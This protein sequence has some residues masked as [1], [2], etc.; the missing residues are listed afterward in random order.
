MENIRYIALL[1]GINVG[2][3]LVKME[4]LRGMFEGLGF[5]HVRSYIQT[6]NIF[7]DSNVLDPQALRMTIEKHLLHSLGYEV[8][9]C[10]R[11]IEEMETLLSLDPFHG[12]EVTPDT[13]FSIT[14]LAE[15]VTDMLPMPYLTP[16]GAYEA[17]GM[18]SSEVFVV[19]HLKDGRPGKSYAHLERKFRI[20]AT[21]RFWKT[22]ADILAAAR[23]S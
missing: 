21:T 14:F 2:G 1:R 3:H 19:W 8:A 15:P 10:I 12:R 22:T 17:I 13:R 6:G 7:F 23:K 20:P 5:E 16:D 9:T 4:Q 11:T 18:T